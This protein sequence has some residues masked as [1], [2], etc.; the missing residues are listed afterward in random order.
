MIIMLIG[1]LVVSLIM[2]VSRIQ[3]DSH[4]DPVELKWIARLK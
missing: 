4:K 2:Q 3:R 1:A